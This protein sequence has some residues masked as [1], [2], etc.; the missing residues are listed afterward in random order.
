MDCR[1]CTVFDPP[2]RSACSSGRK[3]AQVQYTTSPG[4]ECQIEELRRTF[5]SAV[6]DLRARVQLCRSQCAICELF[7]VRSRLHKD[8]HDCLTSHECIHD[9]TLCQ[10]DLFVAEPCGKT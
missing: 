7:C 2:C 8:S 3:V 5:D 1:S 9:C 4:L 10:R 6:I